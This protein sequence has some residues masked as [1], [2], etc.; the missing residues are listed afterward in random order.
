MA[1][2]KRKKIVILDAW[3]TVPGDISWDPIAQMGDL[4]IYDRTPPELVVERIGDAEIVISSKVIIGREVFEQCPNLE[5]IGLLSTGYNVID[6][7]SAREHGVSVC[8]CPGYSTMA[9]AQMA[10]ALLLEITNM[11]GLHADAVNQGAWVESPDW[12]FWLKPH[13]ELLDKTMGIIGFG[14]IGQAAGRMANAFGMKVIGYSRHGHPELET[15][16]THIATDLDEVFANS[17]VILVSCPLNHQSRDII[18]K[19][20]INKMR[21]GV[22]VI[23]IARPGHVVEQDVVD[24]LKSGKMWG[25]GADASSTELTNDHTPLENVENCYLTPHIA[26]CPYETRDRMINMVIEDLRSYLAGDRIN[27][28]NP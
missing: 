5:Y 26:W 11:V 15:A 2:K 9:V 24:A 23:N 1:D 3:A 18:R 25:F 14:E 17:D 21:D 6:I 12:C 4:T 8:N 7:E 27:C 19:E 28:V 16:D 13:M 22:I 20:N 10:M